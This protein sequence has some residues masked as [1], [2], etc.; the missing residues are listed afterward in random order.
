MLVAT[1]HFWTQVPDALVEWVP[2]EQPDLHPNAYGHAFLELYW[3]LHTLGY[4]VSIGPAAPSDAE[5]IVVLL[6]ELID[7]VSL[8][9]LTNTRQTFD[10]AFQSLRLRHPP[11]IVMIRVDLHMQVAAPRM[12]SLAVMPTQASVERAGQV[13]VPMLPQRGLHPR[14]RSRGD[15]LTTVALKGY[16]HNIPA[17]IDDDFGAE[18]RSLGF[19]LRLDTELNNRWRDFSDV[20]VVLC[21]QDESTLEDDRRKPATKLINAWRAGVIP[22][23]GPY[24]AYEEIGNSGETMLVCD[25]TARGYLGALAVLRREPEV[26]ARIRSHLPDQARRY[27]PDNVARLWWE[28]FMVAPR[29]TRGQ[30]ATSSFLLA[31]RLAMR[32][33]RIE[34]FFFA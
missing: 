29:A 19:T 9:H 1:T 33:L 8:Q 24:T 34:R 21:A 13:W 5:V 18:L 22:I 20:D 27:A 17:W 11:K 25:G 4:P 30:L 3:R 2:D 7:W 6:H 32:K 26:A 28:A 14:D 15:Q 16:S 10:L 31:L 23:C 12:A